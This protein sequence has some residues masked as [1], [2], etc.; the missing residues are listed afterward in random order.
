LQTRV[1]KHMGGLPTCCLASSVRQRVRV[2]LNAL[3]IISIPS[4][5]N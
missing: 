4:Q 1:K 2:G 3:F 5:A